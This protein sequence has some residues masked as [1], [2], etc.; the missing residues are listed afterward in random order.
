MT[1]QSKRLER[2]Q[3]G[4]KLKIP[5]DI[6]D[7]PL[8]CEFIEFAQHGLVIRPFR[9]GIDIQQQDGTTLLRIYEEKDGHSYRELLP[10]TLLGKLYNLFIKSPKEDKYLFRGIKK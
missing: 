5:G 10:T 1:I 8:A 3:K 4:I 9:E 2:Q 7:R 6:F